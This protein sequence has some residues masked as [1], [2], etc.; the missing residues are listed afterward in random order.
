MVLAADGQRVRSPPALEQERALVCPLIKFAAATAAARTHTHS[1]AAH[2]T[3]GTRASAHGRFD[4]DWMGTL[5]RHGLNAG[6]LLA[7]WRSCHPLSFPLGPLTCLKHFGQNQRGGRER[8]Q[9][10]GRVGMPLDQEASEPLRTDEPSIRYLGSG[11]VK[12]HALSN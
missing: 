8:C 2:S 12:P 5:D 6:V 7:I 10:T 4:E 9:Q 11:G 3:Q 1:H